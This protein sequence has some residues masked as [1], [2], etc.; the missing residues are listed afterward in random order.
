MTTMMQISS[1]GVEILNCKCVRWRR[2]PIGS[3]TQEC[4]YAHDN[5]ESATCDQRIKVAVRNILL[6]E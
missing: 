4:T 3:F 2:P 1:S 6:K 5:V